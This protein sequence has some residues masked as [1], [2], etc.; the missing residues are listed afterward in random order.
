MDLNHEQREAINCIDHNLQI[1]AC[2]GSGKTEVISRRI[3]NILSTVKDVGPENIVAF[4]FTEKAAENLRNRIGSILKEQGDTDISKM[5]IGTIHSFCYQVLQEYIPELREVKILDTAK[6]HLFA[7]KYFNKCGMHALGLSKRDVALFSDCIDKM[8]SSYECMDKWPQKDKEVFEAYRELLKEKG[9]ISFSFMIYEVLIRSHSSE[10][11]KY[12]SSI[13]YL[14]VDEYQ[15]VDDLQAKLISKIAHSGANIC[16]VGD[17]DQTI[18]Q[19]RGSNADNMMYFS[20]EYDDVVTVNLDINYRS[21]S[22]IL[23]V[24]DCVIQNNEKRLQKEMT[25]VPGNT[26]GRVEGRCCNSKKEEYDCLSYDIKELNSSGISYKDMAI[27]I[28]KRSRLTDLI[29]SLNS[30]A[31]PYRVEE[32]TAFFESRYYTKLCNVYRY[33]AEPTDENRQTLIDDW[34]DRCEPRCLKGAVRY[35]S[36][37]SETKERFSVIL[38]DFINTLEITVTEELERIVQG[39]TEILSDF[40]QI[41]SGDSW[42]VRTGDL[43]IFLDN[44]AET[45]YQ[46]AALFDDGCEEAVSILTVHQSKGLE[47]EAVFIPDM[48]KGFFPAKKVGGKKYYTILGGYFEDN[49][50][51]YESTIED[52]RKLF[53]VAMTRAKRYLYVYADL[54][55]SRP[56]QFLYE[57]LYSDAC[58]FDIPELELWQVYDLKSLRKDLADELYAAAFGAHIG[59]ALLEVSEV[60]KVTD[61]ELIRRAKSYGLNVERYRKI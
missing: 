14:I 43:I 28:R 48:Q 30:N 27:L 45:E 25:A 60:Y 50:D 49:K 4:T 52:E 8:V 21:G 54:E 57:M 24:A 19:F 12:Y 34:K 20:D 41:Y 5:Y 37:C 38:K 10:I 11:Q 59:G 23:D 18:Y 6:E 33:L 9:F 31:I 16:V 15:D 44:M 36:R 40:D 58:S 55:K 29:S 35:L 47:Y 32:N 1:V 7:M 26:E 46:K 2:A 13:K 61:D 53:Y 22:S 3:A 17:D 56:S 39:F 42:T 51:R